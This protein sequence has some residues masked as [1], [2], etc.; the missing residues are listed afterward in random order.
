[1]SKYPSFDVL[2]A[3]VA[4][5]QGIRL[6]DLSEKVAAS[7]TD[8]ESVLRGAAP[9]PLFLKRLAPAL[10]LHAADLFAIAQ[11][12]LPAELAPLN[13]SVGQLIPRLVECALLLTPELRERL[14]HYVRSLPQLDRPQSREALRVDEQY[15]PGPG[16]V[17]M[18][19][20]ANRSLDWTSSAKVL[21]RLGG[22]HLAASS[23]GALGYGRKELTPDLLSPFASVLGIRTSILAVVLAVELP[24]SVVESAPSVGVPELI[25]DVR[26]LDGDQV[27]QVIEEAECL[28]S[29][30]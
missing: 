7:G 25:W 8:F 14:R 28:E 26:R 9:G 5:Q 10:D 2:L 4:D 21:S 19:M 11:V 23:I 18:R 3:R 24:D 6:H 17:L 22:V 12:A 20:L 1:M 30:A 15:M 16:A 29:E 13:M 27:R